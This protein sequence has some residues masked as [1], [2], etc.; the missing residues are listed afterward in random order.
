M[1][2]RD[3]MSDGVMSITDDA[4]VYEA[5]VLLVNS[6]V[7]AMPVVDREGVMVGIVSEADLIRLVEIG[8]DPKDSGLLR[9]LADDVRAAEAFVQANSTRVV[10]VMSKPVISVDENAT[11]GEVADVIMKNRIKRV[12]VVHNR[13]IVGVVSRVDLLKA[14]ISRGPPESAEQAAAA[15]PGDDERL[16]RQVENAVR[17]QSWS[18]AHRADVVV[19]DGVVHLWGMVPSDMVQRAYLVAAEKVPGVR[20]VKNHMHVVSRPGRFT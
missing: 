2:A 16:R 17:G 15:A 1:R 19:S 14:L 13:S 10:D 8:A 18:L 11:L 20:A 9:Q 4:T 5:A 3:V 12:P 7:S 6:Q